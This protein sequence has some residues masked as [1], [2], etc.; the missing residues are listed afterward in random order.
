[1]IAVLATRKENLAV[2]DFDRLYKFY[3]KWKRKAM[4][5]TF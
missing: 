5:V 4:R 1:M 2:C 3:R